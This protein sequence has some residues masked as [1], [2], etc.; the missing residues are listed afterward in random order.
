[1]KPKIIE[2]VC[3][4]I[5]IDL[6]SEKIDKLH[7]FAREVLIWNEKFNLVSKK[8]SNLDAI[9]RH[10]LDSLAIFKI[11]SIPL[12]SKIVD[13]GSGAGFPAIPLKIV[14]E[15]LDLALIESTRKKTLFLK[16]AAEKLHLSGILIL[17]H[18]AE[19]LSLQEQFRKKYDFA[20]AKALTNLL[21]TVK[22]SFPF[23]RAGGLLICYKGEKIEQELEELKKRVKSDIFSILKKE[24]IA[25]PE[26]NL[27][28]NLLVIEKRLDF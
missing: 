2:D 17:N 22:L 13:I 1:M 27:K 25:I 21:Q 6:S 24:S 4:K 20:T 11:L 15:D 12:N 3:S 23:L 16:N 8:D 19:E 28:R 14:R 7:H 5:G 18:R 9:A 26:I 10:I